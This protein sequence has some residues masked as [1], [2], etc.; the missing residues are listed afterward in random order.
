MLFALAFFLHIFDCVVLGL[1][2]QVRMDYP[3]L[4]LRDLAPSCLYFTVTVR[5]D[6][7][8]SYETVN[9]DSSGE[10]EPTKTLW[11]FDVVFCDQQVGVFMCVACT[12][13]FVVLESC[14]VFFRGV[15]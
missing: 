14:F 3:H 4:Y 2:L 12:C 9:A 15:G 1:L 8:F 13:V 10:D 5:V 6:V 7:T 11:S